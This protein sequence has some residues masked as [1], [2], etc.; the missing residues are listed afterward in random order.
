[1]QYHILQYSL[2]MQFHTQDFCMVFGFD[3][4]WWATI[5]LLT[6][7]SS[8]EA[9]EALRKEVDILK[10]K[11]HWKKAYFY[12]WDEVCTGCSELSQKSPSYVVNETW[13]AWW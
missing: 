9:K 12:L 3:E 6:C 1:M 11:T 7:N 4:F 2:G 8:D 5:G 10:T 13:V